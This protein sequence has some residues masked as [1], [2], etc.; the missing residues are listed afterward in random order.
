MN[1]KKLIFDMDGTLLDTMDWWN[2]FIKN[3]HEFDRSK[4]DE[5]FSPDLVNSSSLSYSVS[6]LKD[7]L[8]EV[9]T[10]E[11]LAIVI[12]S[13]IKEYYSEKNRI[14]DH[15]KETL[16]SFYKGGYDLYVA[17]ATD[18]LYAVEGLKKGEIYEYFTH[19]FTPDKVGH[20]KHS[21]EYYQ[22]I[23]QDLGVQPTNCLFFDDASYAI[24]LAQDHGM[25]GVGV[26]DENT[27]DINTLKRISDYYI[28]DFTEIGDLLDN[29]D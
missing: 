25:I 4:I 27:S 15:V 3:F 24:D 22:K 7:Y 16:K 11:G 26:F 13:F 6:M 19:V 20:K 8:D 21:I 1:K 23:T 2:N 9:I 18:Y 14:K 12:H 5:S 29:L 28:S 10:D 17:T